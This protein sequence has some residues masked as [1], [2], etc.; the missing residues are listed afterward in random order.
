[1]PGTVP[2]AHGTSV[3]RRGGSVAARNAPPTTTT[4]AV[5][6]AARFISMHKRKNAAMHDLQPV[7]CCIRAFLHLCIS[8]EPGVRLE[9]GRF[10]GALPRKLRLGAPEVAKGCGLFVDRPPQV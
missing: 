8:S 4:T 3:R 2:S 10:V 9:R 1:M 5:R 7:H 6:I